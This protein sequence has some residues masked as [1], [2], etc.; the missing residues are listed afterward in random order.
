MPADRAMNSG[1]PVHVVYYTSFLCQPL[2]SAIKCWI[3][4][5]L[6]SVLVYWLTIL[7]FIASSSSSN[8]KYNKINILLQDTELCSYQRDPSI[9]VYL[10]I[11]EFAEHKI[12]LLLNTCSDRSMEVKLPNH[13]KLWKT[14]RPPDQLTHPTT[15]GHQ[16]SE[17]GKSHLQWLVAPLT[18]QQQQRLFSY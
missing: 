8:S 18:T 11:Y 9:L 13:W 5:S 15:D 16:G 6:D 14:D 17:G 1:T 10:V 3:A 2:Q 7:L 12:V 4:D